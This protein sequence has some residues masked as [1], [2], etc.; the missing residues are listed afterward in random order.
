MST[1]FPELELL[2]YGMQ[3]S[4]DAMRAA[5]IELDRRQVLIDQ[6]RRS[7]ADHE[8]LIGKLRD[9]LKVDDLDGARDLVNAEYDSI[10]GPA[11]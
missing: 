7:N 4:A 10:H 1:D 5:K 2:K 3:S 9:L 11:D 8:R 6:Y